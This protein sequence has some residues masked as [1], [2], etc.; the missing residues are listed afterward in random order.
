M[1]SSLSKI[2]LFDYI[3]VLL[4]IIPDNKKFSTRNLK[5]MIFDGLDRLEYS[6]SNVKDK[7]FN[8]NNQACFNHLNSIIW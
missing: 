2:Q 3:K 7:Y 8:D 1:K 5:T 6:F 4:I